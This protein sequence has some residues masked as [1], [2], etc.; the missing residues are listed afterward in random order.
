MMIGRQPF[1]WLVHDQAVRVGH[2]RAA[3]RQHLLLAAGQRLGAL[4]AALVQP[5]KQFIDASRFHLCRSGAALGDQQILFDAERREN[6]A[7]LRHQAHAA[8]ARFRMTTCG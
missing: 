6:A 8:C 4:V 3:D 2:Q 5:R 7:A 1:G